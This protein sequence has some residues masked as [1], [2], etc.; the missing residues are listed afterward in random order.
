MNS[1]VKKGLYCALL[2]GGFSLLGV[3]AANAAETSGH[4]ALGSGT[5]VISAVAAPID[6]EGN[7]ISVLG[8]S[9]TSGSDEADTAGAASAP[10]ASSTTSGS[11][12]VASGTQA[13]AEPSA[14]VTVSDNAV[15]VIG[16]SSSSQSSSDASSSDASGSTG[17]GSVGSGAGSAGSTTNGGESIAGGTQVIAGGNAPLTASGD[18]ISFMGDSSTTRLSAEA[19]PSGTKPAS[20][21]DGSDGPA[22]TGYGSIAGG[23]QA[24]TDATATPAVSENEVGVSGALP[25]RPA[26]Q[27]QAAGGAVTGSRGTLTSAPSMSLAALADTGTKPLPLLGLALLFPL[28]GFG[29]MRS[30]SRKQASTA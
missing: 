8:D 10:A 12:G 29:L 7:A 23:S 19:A 17:S 3:G 21:S 26:A 15:S 25:N 13:V 20:G 9:S 14:P 4:D 11:D 27:V 6:V 5:Q 2:V 22:T 24:D 28:A 1:H 16:D 18:S 30:A